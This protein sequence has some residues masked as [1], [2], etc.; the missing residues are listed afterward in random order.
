[1]QQRQAF[2]R[3]GN[4]LMLG[5]FTVCTLV[6]LNDP[7]AMVWIALYGAATILCLRQALATPVASSAALLSVIASVWAAL[8]VPGVIGKT[9]GAEIFAS[10]TMQTKT[11]EQAREIGGLL[12]VAVWMLVLWLSTRNTTPAA[13]GL[14]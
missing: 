8:L 3:Q 14:R 11:A 1:M 7:D 13:E 10:L 4:Y 12:L 6:Q 5:A 2:L 9:T